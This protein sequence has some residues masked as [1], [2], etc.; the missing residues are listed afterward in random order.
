MCTGGILSMKNFHELLTAAK[1]YDTPRV[2]VAVAQDED[3][4][5][6][7]DEAF[8]AELIEPILVGDRQLI[9]ELADRLDIDVDRY[10]IIDEK[11]S[12]LAVKEAV[13]LVSTGEADILMK[14]KVGT[15]ELF[16]EVLN[17][18]RG[19]RTGKILSHVAVMQIQAYH[20]FILMT[21]AAINIEYSISR[22]VN[23]IS[24]VLEVAK[25]LKIEMPKV[26][27]IA[28]VEVVNPDMQATVD[29]AVLSKMCERGQIKDCI[30]DGPYALDVA[31]SAEAAAHKGIKNQVAGDADI[32]LMPNIESGNVMYKSL[33]SFAGTKTAGIVIGARAPIV[34]TSRSD[35]A[36]TK[37]HSIALGILMAKSG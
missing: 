14:G 28:A 26:V 30:I 36:E 37:L 17:K 2:S 6:A 16:R 15:A 22:K 21:D 32:L 5:E 9:H 13:A 33:V 8:K 1:N 4:L 19:L 27:P 20:K 31:I 18:E 24:N 25:V 12:L 7:V 34:V 3:V 10:R 29:A 23:L 11:D 35:S